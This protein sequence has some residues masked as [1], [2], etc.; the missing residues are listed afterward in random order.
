VEI[1]KEILS[2]RKEAHIILL[3][4]NKSMLK[5]LYEA[6]NF[7]KICEVGYYVGGMKEEELKKSESKQ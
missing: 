7:R 2:N 3:A 1:I 6:I 4:H 5:Y